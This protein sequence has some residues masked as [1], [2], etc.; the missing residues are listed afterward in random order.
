[1]PKRKVLAGPLAA[2]PCA[3]PS[4]TP[5]APK[6]ALRQKKKPCYGAGVSKTASGK[7]QARIKLDGKRYDLGSNFETPEEAAAAYSKAKREGRT[8]RPSPKHERIMRGTGTL[9]HIA[10]KSHPACS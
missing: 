10:H 7:F 3:F 2:A 4:A 9:A 8:D 5:S 1:M 6:V